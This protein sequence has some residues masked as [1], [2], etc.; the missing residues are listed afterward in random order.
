MNTSLG[1]VDEAIGRLWEG[2]QR[3]NIS[4]CVNIMIVSDHGMSLYNNSTFVNV[5]DVSRLHR[6]FKI[7]LNDLFQLLP[8]DLISSG[9]LMYPSY[10]TT[11]NIVVDGG[12]FM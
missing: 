8:S 12:K 9:R 3:R 5:D 10:G 4:D 2:L 1:E 7:F 6:V 11:M